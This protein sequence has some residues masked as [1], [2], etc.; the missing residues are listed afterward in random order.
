MLGIF[1]MLAAIKL[2]VLVFLGL[3]ML[4][5]DPPAPVATAPRL[6][7]APLPGPLAGPAPALAQQQGNPLPPATVPPSAN[8]PAA[9]PSSPDV[10]ALLKRQDELD[11]REQ[12]LKTLEAELDNRMGKLKEMETS[13]KAMLEEWDDDKERQRAVDQGEIPDHTWAK[14]VMGM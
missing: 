4:L 9:T 7:V 3:D 14:E 1:V 10:N 11:Q 8:P 6:P 13:I 5:P 12:S 2:G